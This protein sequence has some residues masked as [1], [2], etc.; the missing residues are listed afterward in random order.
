[1]DLRYRYHIVED[2]SYDRGMTNP[3]YSYPGYIFFFKD[4]IPAGPTVAEMIMTKA[5]CQARNG[6][7]EEGL[8][9]ANILRAKRMSNTLSNQEIN[10]SATSQ[11]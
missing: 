11:K 7:W 5:E 2:Y 6:Q 4:R 10:L 3:S 1:M 8:K 9:T